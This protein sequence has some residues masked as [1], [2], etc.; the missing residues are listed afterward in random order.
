MHYCVH[1][2]LISSAS[3]ARLPPT[4]C[5]ASALLSCQVPQL[6]YPSQQQNLALLDAAVPFHLNSAAHQTV[7]THLKCQPQVEAGCLKT[8]TPSST[9][10]G[11]SCPE[12]FLPLST[13]LMLLCLFLVQGSEQRQC[14]LRVSI[15]ISSMN[16]TAQA[17]IYYLSTN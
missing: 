11:E 1:C 16:F 12:S 10:T 13:I 9:A 5:F 3:T 17:Y 4:C 15:L 2:S 7:V 8:I 14:H 6:H